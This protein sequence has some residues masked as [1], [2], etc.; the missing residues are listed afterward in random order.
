MLGF[1]VQIFGFRVQM[2]GFRVQIFSVE[3]LGSC[4]YQRPEVRAMDPG[5]GTVEGKANSRAYLWL[6][7]V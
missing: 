7:V 2:L 1:R 5:P 3:G 6:P 4:L